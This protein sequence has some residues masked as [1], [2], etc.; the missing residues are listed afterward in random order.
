MRV[1]GDLFKLTAFVL[2]S[3]LGLGLIFVVFAQS[4]FRAEQTYHAL[5][6]DVSGLKN[7]QLVRFAGVR[8]GQ[9]QDISVGPN[10]VIDVVFSVQDDVP[11]M[12]GTRVLVRYENLVGDRYLQL[13]QGPGPVRQ[14]PAGAV[15][16]VS[17]TA[18]ALDLDALLGGFQPLFDGLSPPQVNQLSADL[19]AVLQG[20]SG[21]VDR[22]V[23][24]TA[25]LTGTL[26]DRDQ[27]IG[28][29]ITNLNQVLGTI[30]QRDGQLSG[31]LD[32]LQELI[33]GLS[34]ERGKIGDSLGHINHLADSLSSLLDDGRDPLRGTID[35]LGR[36]AKVLD[37]NSHTVDSVITQL[38][39]AYA[40]LSRLGSYGSFF[41]FYLCAVQVKVTGPDGKPVFS[42]EISS[43]SATTRCQVP[44]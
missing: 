34:S 27:V 30:E 31:T 2:V 38:P 22:V 6:A 41:N 16:P 5:F 39:D 29:L 35:E 44:S 10:N 8:V 13:A 17:Q 18:P 20:E 7:G 28:S 1:R 21:T 40:R 12:A 25:S 11:L 3:A 19:I 32:Q 14:L 4:R 26:A 9:V 15:I 24:E 36:T 37:D 43:N 42:P 33:S 23:A